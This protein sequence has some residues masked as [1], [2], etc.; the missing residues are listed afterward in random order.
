MIFGD[1]ILSG[2]DVALLGIYLLVNFI[3][4]LII[5]YNLGKIIMS[6]LSHKR[7]PKKLWQY[8][9]IGLAGLIFAQIII[10]IPK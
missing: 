5:I 2:G 3:S 7:I 10:K 9:A 1:S 6:K 8:T 4:L